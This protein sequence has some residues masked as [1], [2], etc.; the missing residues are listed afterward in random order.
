MQ[1]CEKNTRHNYFFIYTNISCSQTEMY[2][3]CLKVRH[4]D[5]YSAAPYVSQY[6]VHTGAKTEPHVLRSSTPT[7]LNSELFAYK[8]SLRQGGS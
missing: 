7:A 6:T 3:L 5:I 1:E 4:E 8:T 2:L